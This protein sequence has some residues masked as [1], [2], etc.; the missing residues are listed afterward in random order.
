MSVTLKQIASELNIS[1]TTVTNALNGKSRVS[2]EMRRKVQETAERMGYDSSANRAA[3][4]MI[5]KRYGR[6][7]EQG[8]IAL[9]FQMKSPDSAWHFTPFYRSL[10][11]GVEREL[12]RRGID[13]HII[14][15]RESTLP[16]I[17]REQRVDGVIA[18]G[19]IWKVQEQ[20]R[21]LRIPVVTLGS[22]T[23][24]TY[25][26]LPD[27]E[28]GMYQATKYLIDIGHRDIAY[29][30]MGSSLIPNGRIHGHRRA[31]QEN[32]L[33]DDGA[34]IGVIS[35]NQ[36]GQSMPIEDRVAST[37]QTM[38]GK[39]GRC[40]SGKPRFTALVCQNDVMAMMAVRE[41]MAVGLRVPEDLSVVGFDDVSQQYN[42]HPLLTSVAYPAYEMG[43]RAVECICEEVQLLLNPD[44]AS[45]W[46]PKEG[47]EYFPTTLSIH[48]S[49]QAPRC[50][51]STLASKP[52]IYL[53]RSHDE[54]KRHKKHEE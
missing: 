44:T 3:Q 33:D 27:G 12:V 35:P 52:E 2:E 34:L 30:T 7:V 53:K 6:R 17:I 22:H 25:A 9:S 38:L 16:R 20:L 42:F 36:P 19:N 26:I 51:D 48:N 10:S 31:L 8:T 4:T 54:T 45:A 15:Q 41:A 23:E 39:Q 13:L 11:E 47:I 14:L 24:H 40:S 37:L 50:S 5:A 21:D 29:L 43:R 1:H 46:Q 28:G 18:L 32:G 49:T